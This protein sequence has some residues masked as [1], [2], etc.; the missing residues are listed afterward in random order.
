MRRLAM[1]KVFK[2]AAKASA[3][4]GKEGEEEA[5]DPNDLP[6]MD[7]FQKF[8]LDKDGFISKEELGQLLKK[9]LEL[10]TVP[11]DLELSRIMKEVDLDGDG[12][13]DF[14]EFKKMMS[15]EGEDENR[16]YLAT[17]KTFDRDNDGYITYEDLWEVLHLVHPEM[18]EE[19][20]KTIMKAL[21]QDNDGKIS[22]QEFQNYFKI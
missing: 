3:A 10:D 18:K 6:L 11:S 19:E 2:K 13:I 21:D 7:A 9:Y 20:V 5:F 22:Y 12:K 14:K 16:K 4:S 1:W 15:T 17:F 8:D